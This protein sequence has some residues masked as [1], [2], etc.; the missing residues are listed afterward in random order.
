MST[1]TSMRLSCNKMGF[2]INS[3][4]NRT[5]FYIEIIYTYFDRLF[6]FPASSLREKY[7]LFR[8]RWRWNGVDNGHNG[9]IHD[10]EWNARLRCSVCVLIVT[11]WVLQWK[12]RGEWRREITAAKTESQRIMLR[13]LRWHWSCTRISVSDCIASILYFSYFFLNVSFVH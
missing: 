2:R 8:R 7:S 4:V 3:I 6:A 13:R 11:T 5:K 9:F 12:E 10:F 1:M